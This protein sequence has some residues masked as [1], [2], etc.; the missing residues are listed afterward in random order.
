MRSIPVNQLARMQAAQVAAMFD[1][2]VPMR[3]SESFDAM[4]HPVPVWIDAEP[5]ACGLDMVGGSEID[6]DGRILVTWD[7]EIRLPLGTILE[8]KDRVRIISRF[9]VADEPRLEYEVAGP[10]RKGPSGLVVRLKRVLPR[11]V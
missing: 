11:V 8:P 3:Y 1:L 10:A 7:A 2:C 4:H 6:G 5:V 9:G